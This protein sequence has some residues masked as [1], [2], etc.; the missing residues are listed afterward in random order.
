MNLLLFQEEFKTEDDCCN[1]L[2]KTRWAH[3]FRAHDVTIVRIFLLP[4]E[5][6]MNAYNVTTNFR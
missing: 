1:W 3:G 2:F 6:N 4:L 5:K